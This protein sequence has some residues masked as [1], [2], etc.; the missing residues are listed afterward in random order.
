MRQKTAANPRPKLTIPRVLALLPLALVRARCVGSGVASGDAEGR[1]GW[2]RLPRFICVIAGM[3]VMIGVVPAGAVAGAPGDSPPPVIQAY[4]EE[5]GVS[6]AG[7][8]RQL[9]IQSDG[10]PVVELLRHREG[11]DYAGVWF[12][13]SNGRFVIPIL[14]SQ[15]RSD[16]RFKAAW[17]SY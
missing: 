5:F 11:D 7:A 8:E 14:Q 6:R 3:L 4:E 10:V 9:A 2:K 17:I 16:L 13:N 12:D 1:Q 15:D